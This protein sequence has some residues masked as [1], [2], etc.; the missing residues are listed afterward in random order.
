GPTCIAYETVTDNDGRL[1]LL[2]PMSEVAGR[3]SIQVGA[4]YLEKAHGGRG[5]LMGG[6]PG[7]RPADVVILGAGVSGYNA[8]QIAVGMRERVTVFDEHPSR[9]GTSAREIHA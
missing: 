4:H 2:K 9:L 5:V 8:A 6:V 7:V 1:P 3:M